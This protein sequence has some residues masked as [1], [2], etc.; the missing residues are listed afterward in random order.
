PRTEGAHVQPYG[1]GAGAAV[2]EEGDG[3]VGIGLVALEIRHVRHGGMHRGRRRIV[4]LVMRRWRVL[5]F[6]ILEIDDLH[7]GLGLVGDLCTACVDRGGGALALI[8]E[9]AWRGKFLAGGV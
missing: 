6:W 9:I 1:R 5:V 7:A 3:P 4:V 2:E 8:L